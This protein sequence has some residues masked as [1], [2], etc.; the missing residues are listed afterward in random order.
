MKAGLILIAVG[1]GLLAYSAD[2]DSVKKESDAPKLISAILQEDKELYSREMSRLLNQPMAEFK[3]AVSFKTEQGDT[4][5]HLMA[6]V[7]SHQEFFAKEIQTLSH[8]FNINHLEW[9]K[10]ESL[11]S[12]GGV[13]IS[14]PDLEDTKLGQAI[15]N[16]DVST[17]VSMANQLE[18]MSVIKL[19]QYSYAISRNKNLSYI[20]GGDLMR[21]QNIKEKIRKYTLASFYKMKNQEGLLPKDIASKS[22]NIPAYSLFV[23]LENLWDYH[24]RDRVALLGGMATIVVTM[25]VFIFPGIDHGPLEHLGPLAVLPALPAGLAG[26]FV[27][28]R[29]YRIFQKMKTKSL[30]NK[31]N[32]I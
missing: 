32:A 15:Y 21:N 22:K 23:E 24:K 11:V 25:S 12:L 4:I 10:Q 13:N 18:E 5:F 20:Y 14:L 3:E 19:L 31:L 2:V 1:A 6:G 27:S 29:C 30:S 17:L 7:K 28:G 8:F 26:S 9:P 16:Q